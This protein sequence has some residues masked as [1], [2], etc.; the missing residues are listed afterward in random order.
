MDVPSQNV[1]EE[2]KKDQSKEKIQKILKENILK[3]FNQIKKGCC[4][5]I[6]FN[7]FCHKNLI[8]KKS[9]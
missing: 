1:K 9:K 8:C 4:R 6:C 2:E 5:N 7:I 3:I